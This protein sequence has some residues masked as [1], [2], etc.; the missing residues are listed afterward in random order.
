MRIKTIFTIIILVMFIMLH[1]SCKPMVDIPSEVWEEALK[2]ADETGVL[3]YDPVS[4][5][6][7]MRSW[8]FEDPDLTESLEFK[9]PYVSWTVESRSLG[10]TANDQ[11]K[12]QAIVN[13]LG[14]P[15]IMKLPFENT[16]KGELVFDYRNNPGVGAGKVA[17]WIDGDFENDPPPFLA[18]SYF[19]SW[20]S[21]SYPE[22]L[23][24]GL[25]F[26]TFGAQSFIS[27]NVAVSVDNISMKAIAPEIK[28]NS[29]YKVSMTTETDRADIYYTT[30]GSEPTQNSD[31]YFGPFYASVGQTIKAKAFYPKWKSSNTSE[32]KVLALSTLPFSEDF[33]TDPGWTVL[34]KS[35]GNIWAWDNGS[36]R[37]EVSYS[38]STEDSWLITPPIQLIGYD[39]YRVSFD[40][41]WR[42]GYSGSFSD[43]YIYVSIDQGNNWDLLAHPHS[44]DGSG[45][46]TE[47]G[48]QTYSLNDY[49]GQNVQ[50]AWRYHAEY[51]WWWYIDNVL[52]EGWN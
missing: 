23:E 4:G 39:N 46:H 16:S 32:L 19:T 36:L 41:E 25:H 35:T 18:D 38:G 30:D 31:M 24:P 37:M 50:L 42:G 34:Q 11:Y 27:G 1:P 22:Y 12:A 52:V 26:L 44:D 20:T 8:D 2:L 15:A 10:A 43:G 9:E 21:L 33:T 3:K 14:Q 51:D 6:P 48:S 13:G 17:L 40:E 7:V 49:A 47:T 29:A 45:D 5:L 28:Y